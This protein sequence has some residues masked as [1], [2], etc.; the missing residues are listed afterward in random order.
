MRLEIRGFGLLVWLRPSF[1]TMRTNFNP[2]VGT[3]LVRKYGEHP[4]MVLGMGTR[5]K[6][7]YCFCCACYFYWLPVQHQIPALAFE[8]FEY[9]FL[10]RLFGLT[11]MHPGK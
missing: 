4:P 8:R 6:C 2:K 11:L 1:I 5:N 9:K 7:A 3:Y 10:I